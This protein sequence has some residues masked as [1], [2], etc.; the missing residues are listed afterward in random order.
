MPFGLPFFFSFLWIVYWYKSV[1][2]STLSVGIYPRDF[3]GLQGV[4]LSP[5]IHENL[6][7]LYKTLFRFS[8]IGSDAIFL[9]KQSFAVMLWDFVS[10]NNLD[11]W[12]LNI[13]RASGL[14]I[15]VAYFF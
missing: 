6:S 3:S 15:L 8:I 11:Y 5:F 9:P 14:I 10:D 13:Y 1:L 4:L 2:I 12:P 7:H